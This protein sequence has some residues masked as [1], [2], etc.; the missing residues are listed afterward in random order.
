MAEAGF[1]GN[2]RVSTDGGSGNPLN[3]CNSITVN[4]GRNLLDITDFEDSAVNRLA[5]LK[6][7]SV[8]LSGHY[9][10]ADTAQAALE[11]AFDAGTVIY[12]RHVWD[13]TKYIQV[14]GLVES[15]EVSATPSETV[16]FSV[17]VQAIAAWTTG[18]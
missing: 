9:D 10:A 14:Q 2:V 11:T 18:P 4:R 7:S 3:G 1:E 6:D 8:Q 16:T 15:H 12:I 17:T 5:G 13:G